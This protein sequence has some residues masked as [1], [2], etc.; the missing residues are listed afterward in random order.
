MRFK[1]PS[2]PISRLHELLTYD[3]STGLLHWKVRRNQCAV[4]GAVAGHKANCRGKLYFRVRVDDQLIMGHWIVWAM[5][6]GEWPTD[7][8]DHADGDGLNNR[9]GNLQV[10]SQADNNKNAAIRK[11]NKTGVAGVTLSRNGSFV[12]SIRVGGKQLT[13]GTFNDLED[14]ATVRKETEK[15]LGFHPNHGRDQKHLLRK[16]RK[17]EVCE[18]A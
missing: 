9:Q 5:L 18:S 11:D 10:A 15:A 7:Q 3:Q 2:L 12:A 8:I 6:H 1:Q 16:C 14:A 4:A 17:E 13:L